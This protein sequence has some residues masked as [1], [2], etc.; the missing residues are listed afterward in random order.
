MQ[1]TDAVVRLQNLS[2]TWETCGVDRLRGIRPEGLQLDAD[3]WGPTSASFTLRRDPG[4]IWPD[5]LAFTPVEIEVGGV[6]V[7]SGFI[8]QTPSN[9]TDG[10]SIN[11][12]C[13]GWQ[14]HLDDDSFEKVW[15]SSSTSAWKDARSFTDTN[16]SYFP[17]GPPQPT[18]DNGAITLGWA[19][20]NQLQANTHV[21]IILDVGP[22][23]K[24]TGVSIDYSVPKNISGSSLNSTSANVKIYG[25]ST[26]TI[27][28]F[29]TVSNDA[30]TA[31]AMPAVG[32][33]SSLSGAFPSAGRYVL[34]SLAY[35]GT[36]G[37]SGANYMIKINGIRVTT[38]TAYS[39]G[40]ITGQIASQ[41][42]KDCLVKAPLL[43]QSTTGITST[44]FSIPQFGSVDGGKTPRE[45]I[46]NVN[47]YHDYV[48]KI[49]AD[50][51][52]I[53]KPQPSAPT[54]AIGKWGGATFE[55][56]SSNSSE[57]IYNKV[58]VEGTSP[59]GDKMRVT[60]YPAMLSSTSLTSTPESVGSSL[61]PGIRANGW[62]VYT[63]G[64]ITGVNNDLV[65]QATSDHGFSVGDL[66]TFSGWTPAGYN[67]VRV[68]TQATYLGS[69]VRFTTNNPNGL[70]PAVANPI[71]TYGVV[72]AGNWA[73]T[74]NATLGSS[75]LNSTSAL[76]WSLTA[77]TGQSTITATVGSGYTFKAGV[78]YT[79]S[80]SLASSFA[81]TANVGYLPSIKF[82]IVGG[83]DYVTSVAATDYIYGTISSPRKV[84]ITWTPSQ[85]YN[86]ATASVQLALTSNFPLDYAAT[87]D[88][89]L[90]NQITAVSNR[91]ATMADRRGFFRT[92]RLQVNSTITQ[93]VGQTLGDVFL[94]AH[95]TTPL[96]GTVTVNPGGARDYLSGAAVHPSQLLGLVGEKMHLSHRT[97]PDNGAQGRDGFIAAVSYSHDTQ[98]ASVS[99]D[100]QRNRFE[101]LLERLA[102]VSNTS[103]GQ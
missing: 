56:A 88:Y 46:N 96:K 92:K 93:Q 26:D 94:T 91:S 7:W 68:V 33:S 28:S 101:A 11:V 6:V 73:A 16:I 9:E 83:S 63:T 45:Y 82:G 25:R 42:V 53:F 103:L 66:V 57:E 32:A 72:N 10:G 21:G 19:S 90:I 48:T 50:K 84:S 100:N 81:Y 43:N 34:I 79:L 71:S 55:D 60:R 54:V 8:K 49:T 98:S 85:D 102:V 17:T 69:S 58:V 97:N 20:G 30:W 77:T 22:E 35:T 3:S 64:G 47:S 52:L 13:A 4:S 87:T 40:T 29:A 74:T 2:G 15:V 14:Y 44:T 67:G 24:A 62:R 39:S 31:T 5:L 41:I 89:Y 75:T 59:N 76:Q 1:T 12:Q 95:M 70:D 99:I 61:L 37:Q 86:T 36:S 65:W 38:D 80:F 51:R 78:S 23:N 27:S 18:T